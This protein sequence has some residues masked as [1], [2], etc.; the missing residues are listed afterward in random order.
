MMELPR[1][2]RRALE[3]GDE[4]RVEACINKA[5]K[6]GWTLSDL[7]KSFKALRKQLAYRS[8]KPGANTGQL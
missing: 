7:I 5:K 3:S 2:L 6:E 4:K 1:H 8:I